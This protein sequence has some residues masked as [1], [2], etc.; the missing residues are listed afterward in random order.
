[1][2]VQPGGRRGGLPL[3]RRQHRPDVAIWHGQLGVLSKADAI[4]PGLSGGEGA[5][6]RCGE[7]ARRQSAAGGG[8]LGG[9]H[10]K[11]EVS[12]PSPC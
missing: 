10:S 8:G 5:P 3:Q 1:M 6:A 11:A 2:G 4:V 12:T 9:G 7:G